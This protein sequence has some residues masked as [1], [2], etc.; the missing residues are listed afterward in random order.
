M[1]D[2]PATIRLADGVAGLDKAQ[3]DALT[4]GNPFVAHGFLSAMEASGSVG[5]GTGWQACPI[6]VDG[7]DGTLTG[8]LPAYIKT[9]SMGEYVF[10]HSWADAFERAGG[11]YYP[12]LLI[13]APFTPATGPRI[14]AHDKATALLLLLGAEA[15]VARHTL[16]SAHANFIAENERAIFADAGWLLRQ[17]VQFHW[18]ND[19]YADFED[20]LASLSSRKRKAIRKERAAAQAAV[21]IRILRGPEI[22]EAQWDV[23]WCAKMGPTLSDPRGFQRDGTATWRSIGVVSCV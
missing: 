3:W 5:A 13:A 9:H 15:F 1:S 23:Y 20:F 18:Y 11:Q 22:G 21:D 19:G 6:L 2:A 14:L 8:A 7:A 12:K 16:S 10:D 4:D 17:G